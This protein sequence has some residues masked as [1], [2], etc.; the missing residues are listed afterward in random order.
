MPGAY[1]FDTVPFPTSTLRNDVYRPPVAPSP[2]DS[3][4]NLA[5]STG[6]LFSEISA[7][8]N[9]YEASAAMKRKRTAPDS[10]E[11]TP[12]AEWGDMSL[13]TPRSHTLVSPDTDVFGRLWQQMGGAT[14]KSG[15]SY[16]LAG[17]IDVLNGPGVR[18][19]ED[20][21]ISDVNYR[22]ALGPQDAGSAS[23]AYADDGLDQGNWSVLQALGS[24]VG[25]VWEFCKAGAFRGFHA[26]GGEGYDWN[27]GKPT[28]PPSGVAARF[29]DGDD[30][31]NGMQDTESA[32]RLDESATD[33]VSFATGSYLSSWDANVQ[34]SE[35]D[36][37]NSRRN[38]KR[39]Q[40]G[41]LGDDLGRNWVM[42]EPKRDEK[43]TLSRASTGGAARTSERQGGRLRT[44]ARSSNA[45]SRRINTPVSRI[46]ATANSSSHRQPRVSHAGSPALSSRAQASFASPR[47]AT[48]PPEARPFSPDKSYSPGGSRIPLPMARVETSNPFARVSSPRPGSRAGS[49]SKNAP[50]SPITGGQTP[51]RAGQ[52]GHRRSDSGR[53]GIS[54]LVKNPSTYEAVQGAIKESPRLNDEAKRLA[55]QN[56]AAGKNAD[57]RI[58]A[59]NLRLKE[60]IRQG[61]EALGTTFVVEGDAEQDDFWAD[62][63]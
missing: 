62:D 21:V 58:E 17:Q 37:P 44:A 61:Q 35:R 13:E 10:R 53:I 16:T 55:A 9:T 63:I 32:H 59:F 54:P 6:S 47:S 5:Q 51:N 11:A 23:L 41:V 27:T 43:S 29:R 26:G 34:A 28:E 3:V 42:V 22:R 36:D 38:G 24:V 14:T 52:R 46:G 56:I 48:P 12:T 19:L 18:A 49:Q 1:N 40:V 25:K 60:M 31:T 50:L 39:R 15:L 7:P 20:S 45:A 57:A 30:L 8:N 4:A 2:T 33:L